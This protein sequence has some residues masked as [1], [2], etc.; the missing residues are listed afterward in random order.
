[1]CYT[2]LEQVM[3]ILGEQEEKE[4]KITNKKVKSLHEITG[5]RIMKEKPLSRNTVA[6]G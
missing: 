2:H 5:F 4:G 6:P 3:F 1:M